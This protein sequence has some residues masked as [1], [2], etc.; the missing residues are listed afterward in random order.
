MDDQSNIRCKKQEASTKVVKKSEAKKQGSPASLSLASLLLCF[1]L[2]LV[3]G[4]S[5][6]YPKHDIE[7]SVRKLFRKELKVEAQ[8]RLI[9]KTLYVGFQIEGLMSKDAQLSKQVID[10]LENAMISI[11]RISLSTDADISYTV[12]EATDPLWGVQIR[13][14]R[15]MQDLKDLF[16]WGISKPD[17]DDRLILDIKRARGISSQRVPGSIKPVVVTEDLDAGTQWHDLTLDEFMAQ[18]LASR[19]YWNMRSNPFMNVLI[20][21][22]MAGSRIDKENKMLYLI[23]RGLTKSPDEDLS[24]QLD[25]FQTNVIEQI[26]QI[27][28]KYVLSSSAQRGKK[29]SD[30]TSSIWVDQVVIQDPDGNI[31]LKI[32]R[33][34]WLKKVPKN[35]TK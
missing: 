14:V 20:P 21:I 5:P 34:Q 33:E 8:S 27:E 2:F 9:G 17:Y 32:P 31:L 6:T 4:C 35:L 28:E 7:Q 11:S 30:G 15:K 19:V 26:R 16:Y 18:L 10:Q 13:V 3:S 24:L 25:M 12:I 1:L 22:E 29:K 23:V